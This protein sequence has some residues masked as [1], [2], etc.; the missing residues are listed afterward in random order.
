MN[1]LFYDRKN[2]RKV[3]SKDLMKINLIENYA[4]I[5]TDDTFIETGRR[6]LPLTCESITH[7]QYKEIL[8][9]DD[10]KN[11]Y[12]VDLPRWDDLAIEKTPIVLYN[13]ER[14]ISNVGYKSDHCP[15][16]QNW[17]LHC[18]ESD[19]VFLELIE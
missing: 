7:E 1:V 9:N 3:S 15:K 18:Q 11:S 2:K 12:N 8:N 13:H 5:D 10:Y 6:I 17:D 4:T 19:L 16:N 14:V